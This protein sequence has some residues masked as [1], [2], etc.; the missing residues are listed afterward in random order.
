M[1][2]YGDGSKTFAGIDGAL[3]GKLENGMLYVP[4]S[5]GKLQLAS[6]VVTLGGCKF[7][8]DPVTHTVAS[9]GRM[10]MAFGITSM[11]AVALALAGFSKA[12]LGITSIKQRRN[13][14]WVI[15]TRNMVLR[16]LRSREHA[17]RMASIWAEPGLARWQ[18]R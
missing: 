13:G 16:R 7:N 4:D 17:N 2:R 5:E 15:M 1:G 18:R 10:L 12:A 9:A 6:G 11:K 3:C 8:V 14:Y